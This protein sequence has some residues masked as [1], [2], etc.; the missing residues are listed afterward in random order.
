MLE[1]CK[2]LSIRQS[3]L[4]HHLKILAKA[5]IVCTRKEGNSIF[6]RRSLLKDDDP[7]REIKESI[8]ESVDKIP[9]PNDIKRRIE[10][11]QV[12]RAEQSL[13]FF[14]KNADK[15]QEKQ[16][17]IV[18]H[19]DYATNIH[20]VIASLNISDESQILEVGQGKVSYFPNLRRNLKI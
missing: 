20:D 6:Y 11:I 1:L 5:E 13:S 10:H 17:L 18:E 19:A 15:F 2:I 14:R 9:L 3:A 8:L 12:E 16:G 4:S 7:Y